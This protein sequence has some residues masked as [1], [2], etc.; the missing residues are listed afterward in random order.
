METRPISSSG[1]GSVL[2]F[3]G[4]ALGR[5]CGVD[6]ALQ[7][8]KQLPKSA[9]WRAARALGMHIRDESSEG[10]PIGSRIRADEV[11]KRIGF[12][13]HAFAPALDIGE[14]GPLGGRPA[15]PM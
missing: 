8:A 12:G 15:R 14:T 2:R 10:C 9:R 7:L 3:S 6:D 11:R 4:S 13:Q 1:I 5:G